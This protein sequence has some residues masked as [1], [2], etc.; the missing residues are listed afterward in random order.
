[1]EYRIFFSKV[2]WKKVWIQP[3]AGGQRPLSQ[4]RRAGDRIQGIGVG[5]PWPCTRHGLPRPW[6]SPSLVPLARQPSGCAEPPRPLGR[7]QNRFGP[8]H[9]RKNGIL[10]FFDDGDNRM[11]PSG[12]S[13]ALVNVWQAS[14]GF[15]GNGTNLHTPPPLSLL[16]Q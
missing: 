3:G 4:Q 16:C 13:T 5:W 2:R 12:E 14:C 15:G 9:S 1:M 8:H 11:S 6:P 7:S 10:I